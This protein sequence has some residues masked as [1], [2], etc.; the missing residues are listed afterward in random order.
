M[1]RPDVLSAVG[2][3]SRF[4]YFPEQASM[5]AAKGVLRHLRGT[6]RL[7]VAYGSREPLQN[8]VDADW[9][10]DVDGRRSTTGFIF[11]VNSG[12]VA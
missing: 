3:L 12:P 10:G 4:M 8:Y 7:G 2:V 9:A 5:R 1:T 11:N 6:T